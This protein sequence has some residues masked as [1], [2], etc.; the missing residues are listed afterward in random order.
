MDKLPKPGL[1]GSYSGSCVA[2]LQ[3]TDTALAF[4][5]E[6]EWLIAGLTRLGIPDDQ[7][8]VMVSQGLGSPAGQVPD[9]NT[10]ELAFRVCQKCVDGS[11][12]P[13]VGIPPNV[14]VIEQPPT[15]R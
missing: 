9:V 10:V 3:G 5:G 8:T 1:D 11:P 12:F 6:P 7:A 15:L 14:P 4:R 2:C 13:A